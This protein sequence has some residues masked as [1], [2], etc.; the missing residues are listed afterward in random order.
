MKADESMDEWMNE[1]VKKKK[2]FMEPARD[3][4][5]RIDPSTPVGEV[6]AHPVAIIPR[7]LSP[8]CAGKAARGLY[9]QDGIP[10]PVRGPTLA[11]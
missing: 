7:N 9:S 1:W 5:F 8:L 3:E 6:F 10:G 4:S 11:L 2:N